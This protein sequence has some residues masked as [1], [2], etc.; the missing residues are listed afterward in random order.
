MADDECFVEAG[1][2]LVYSKTSRSDELVCVREACVQALS[3]DM[4]EVAVCAAPLRRQCSVHIHPV[5]VYLFDQ[6][7]NSF[8]VRFARC[9]PVAR[10]FSKSTARVSCNAPVPKPRLRYCS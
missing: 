8:L 9:C 4:H 6:I 1:Q 7:I 5:R 3:R 10:Q 2:Q